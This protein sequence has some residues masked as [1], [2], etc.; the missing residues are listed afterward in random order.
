MNSELFLKDIQREEGVDRIKA[1]LV[2]P[3]AALY[4]AIMPGCVR[5]DQLMLDAQLGG[6]FLE[7]GSG[8]PVYWRGGRPSHPPRSFHPGEPSAGKVLAY[9]S[10][11]SSPVGTCPVC[12]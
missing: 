2:F 9:R 6:G 11:S 3:V 7:K 4:L 1:F 10:F 5:T 12:A 8:Y